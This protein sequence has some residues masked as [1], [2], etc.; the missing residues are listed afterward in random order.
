M[1]SRCLPGSLSPS[2]ETGQLPLLAGELTAWATRSAHL[3]LRLSSWGVRECLPVEIVT[4]CLS[5][6]C[7]LCARGRVRFQ[8][9]GLGLDIHGGGGEG[10]WEQAG[11]P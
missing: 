11:D 10:R 7:L 9:H 8:G 6:E 1:T 2:G 5:K 3:H 4:L